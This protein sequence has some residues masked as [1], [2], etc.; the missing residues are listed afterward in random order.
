MK[1]VILDIWQ[2]KRTL[3]IVFIKTQRPD[4]TVMM[5]DDQSVVRKYPP[6]DDY[7]TGNDIVWEDPT[8]GT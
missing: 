3:D 2:N 7:V 8:V 5:S 6:L 4:G 1:K